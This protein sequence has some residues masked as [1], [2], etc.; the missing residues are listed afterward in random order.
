MNNFFK[1]VGS[2][3]WGCVGGAQL[4]CSL[5]FWLVFCYESAVHEGL[6]AGRM[7]YLALVAAIFGAGGGVLFWFAWVK[8]LRERLGLERPTMRKK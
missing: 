3:M 2:S 8:P 1:W 6:T 5:P 7:L 4:C